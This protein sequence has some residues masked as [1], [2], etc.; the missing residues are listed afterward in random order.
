MTAVAAIALLSGC[1]SLVVTPD[2]DGPLGVVEVGTPLRVAVEY[3]GRR[4]F[5]PRTIVAGREAKLRAEYRTR[6]EYATSDGGW[7]TLA[8]VNPLVYLGCPT[9]YDS[10]TVRG[11][12][13][14]LVGD[15]VVKT[16]QARAVAGRWRGLY[17]WTRFSDL[18]RTALLAVRDRIEAL[19]RQ[20]RTSWAVARTAPTRSGG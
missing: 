9:G 16:Y 20:D 17:V 14:L 8:S 5:L 1:G 6:S 11:E 2:L 13:R 15:R 18:R 12:L 7:A 10:A 19:M 3:W 4:E